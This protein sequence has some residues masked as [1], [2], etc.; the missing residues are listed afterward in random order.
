MLIRPATKRDIDA[1]VDMHFK[2]GLRRI[3]VSFVHQYPA[4]DLGE[5]LSDL[6]HQWRL[7]RI[8]DEV[9]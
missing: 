9:S 5:R 7:E 2:I 3:Q 4:L 6:D 8:K 1:I